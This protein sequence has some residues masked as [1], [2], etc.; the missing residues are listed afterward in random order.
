MFFSEMLAR[1]GIPVLMIP[2]FESIKDRRGKRDSLMV[3]HF[4]KVSSKFGFAILYDYFSKNEH[5]YCYGCGQKQ[6][7]RVFVLYSPFLFFEVNR[8]TKEHALG[9]IRKILLYFQIG[10]YK[11]LPENRSG[12]TAGELESKSLGQTLVFLEAYH[13]L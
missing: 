11:Y 10:L 3:L 5:F 9:N 12:Q 2:P 13:R 7:T 8:I 6:H 1:I 4:C